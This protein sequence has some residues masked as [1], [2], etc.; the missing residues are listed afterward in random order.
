MSETSEW[1]Q[2][3]KCIGCGL[4][5]EGRECTN[6]EIVADDRAGWDGSAVHDCVCWECRGPFLRSRKLLVQ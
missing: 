5:I 3:F 4:V 2:R 6:G 1:R